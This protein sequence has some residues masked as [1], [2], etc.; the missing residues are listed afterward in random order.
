MLAVADIFQ[1]VCYE[2]VTRLAGHLHPRSSQLLLPGDAQCLFPAPHGTGVSDCCLAGPS[3]LA[4]RCSLQA[5]QRAAR[6]EQLL[7]IQHDAVQKQASIEQ[8]SC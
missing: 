6:G 4:G 5:G 1:H 3:Q 2:R 8:P 7:P